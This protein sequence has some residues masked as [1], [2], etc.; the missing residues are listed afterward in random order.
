MK[1]LAWATRAA[2]HGHQRMM[3]REL[4]DATALTTI[5]DAFEALVHEKPDQPASP[6]ARDIIDTINAQWSA[7]TL[8][9]RIRVARD[10][11]LARRAQRLGLFTWGRGK[12]HH[13][14]MPLRD[15]L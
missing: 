1:S 15:S 9:D 13:N 14:R 10:E 3:H 8:T 11:P 5:C 12:R 2:A 6:L 4:Q 7:G